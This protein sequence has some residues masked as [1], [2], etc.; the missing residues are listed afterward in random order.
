[1][2]RAKPIWKSI[3]ASL[4]EDI[5][6]A[7]YDP[8]DK[9]PPETQLAARFG[10]N[11]HTVR[12]ALAALAEQGLVYPRRG[13]GVYVTQKPTDY[14]LGRR[15][16][17]HRNLIAQGRV[18]AK[19]VLNVETRAADIDEAA[20]LDI[21]P[22]ATVQVYEGLSL[23]DGQPISIFRS[24]FP[25]A[26]FPGLADRLRSGGSVTEALHEQGVP[27]YTRATTRINALTATISQSLHLRIPENAPVLRTIAVNIDAD[28]RPVEYG[29]AWFAGD[30]VTLTLNGQVE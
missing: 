13:A 18:P 29:T 5:A 17:Y 20:A 28:A 26:R 1:M 9:L 22:G 16:R 7:R 21:E 24:V 3:A 14:A 23:A 4:T 6:A 8:G 11:R 2:S 30:R 27:D 10:V 25:A 12:R 19:Q 15:V